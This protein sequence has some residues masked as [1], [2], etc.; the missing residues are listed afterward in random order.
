MKVRIIELPKKKPE[1]EPFGIEIMFNTKEEVTNMWKAIDDVVGF[2]CEV[3][4]TL[5]EYMNKH[6]L[7]RD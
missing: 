4:D 7:K 1:F 5:N 2:T 3:W 6:N